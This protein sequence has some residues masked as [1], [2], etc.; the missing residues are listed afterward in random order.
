MNALGAEQDLY[1]VNGGIIIQKLFCNLI[2]LVI[3]TILSY[4]RGTLYVVNHSLMSQS[5]NA[6]GVHV[7]LFWEAQKSMCDY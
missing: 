2:V 1:Y 7:H 5:H 3:K 4:S 6:G